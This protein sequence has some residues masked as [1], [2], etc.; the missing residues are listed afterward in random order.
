MKAK[1]NYNFTYKGMRLD[2]YRVATV[3]NITHPI[4]QHIVKK[5]MRGTRKGHTEEQIVAE[6]Y[7]AVVRWKQMIQED[8]GIVFDTCTSPKP[9]VDLCSLT[10]KKKYTPPKSKDI[11]LYLKKYKKTLQ[12]NK[13]KWIGGIG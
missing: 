8:K 1:D 12:S 13:Q 3:C 5:L 7:D 6:V 4:A 11:S 9:I 2:F 10:K